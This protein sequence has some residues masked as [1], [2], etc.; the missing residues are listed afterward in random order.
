MFIKFCGFTSEEDLQAAAVFPISAA[1]FIFYEKSKR[2]ISPETAKKISAVLNGKNIYRVGIFVDSSIEFI[3]SASE[4]ARLDYIQLYDP[5]LI[6]SLRGFRP[7]LVSY[8]IRRKD[9]LKKIVRPD[10]GSLILIDS[11]HPDFYGGTGEKIDWN[12]LGEFEYID[13][14][15]IAGGINEQNV[16]LLLNSI[17]PYGI[18][19]SSGIEVSPGKKSVDKM[20]S[21]IKKING[22]SA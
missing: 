7:M 15:I 2:Y 4:I 22:V 3:K 14:T 8:R 6:K 1:G 18:D 16:E 17:R 21:I 20:E 19:I 9:D 11:Y 5:G 12:F 13:K 10:E